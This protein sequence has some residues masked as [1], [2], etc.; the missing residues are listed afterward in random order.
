MIAPGPL[1][2]PQRMWLCPARQVSHTTSVNII[3]DSHIGSVVSDNNPSRNLFWETVAGCWQAFKYTR[4]LRG[5]PHTKHILWFSITRAI[6]QSSNRSLCTHVLQ[7][8]SALSFNLTSTRSTRR[9][10]R[11]KTVIRRLSHNYLFRRIVR[12]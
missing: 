12:F 8:N 1:L 7:K 11:Y 3:C 2:L 4:L 9:S 5:H 10:H 6:C